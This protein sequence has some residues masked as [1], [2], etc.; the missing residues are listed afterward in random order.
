MGL[1]TRQVRLSGGG[2][3]SELWRQ[4]QAD[5][6]GRTCVTV[7]AAEGPALGAAL[8]GAVGVG[9][10]RNVAQACKA[11]IRITRTIRPSARARRRY[12][13]LYDQYRRLYLALRHEFARI[14]ELQ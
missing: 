14:A 4:I 9:H 3:R 7:N 12:S 1:E 10:F 5:I 13:Q 6:Y 8:L 11:C 2:A